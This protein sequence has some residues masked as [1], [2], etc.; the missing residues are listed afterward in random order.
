MKVKELQIGDVFRVISTP[1]EWVV[2]RLTWRKVTN[3][4]AEAVAHLPAR[5]L[6]LD[7][8]AAAAVEV[9]ERAEA[10][11]IRRVGNTLVLK[12]G[13]VLLQYTGA[14]RVLRCTPKAMITEVVLSGSSLHRS[15]T[16]AVDAATALHFEINSGARELGRPSR[17]TIF[18]YQGRVYGRAT[19][20]EILG[21]KGTGG[22]KR[23]VKVD[24]EQRLLIVGL[25]TIPDE[26]ELYD[27]IQDHFGQ[28]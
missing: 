20:Y 25:L 4:R 24:G 15:E 21:K 14:W 6:D 27:I 7:G 8:Y 3:H 11:P 18:A 1:P 2:S 23:L 10:A 16:K 22:Y 28:G 5:T 26:G 17:S 12:G 19:Q 9:I 13:D